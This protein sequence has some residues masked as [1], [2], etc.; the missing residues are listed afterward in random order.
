TLWDELRDV[1]LFWVGH[2]VKIFRVDNPHTKP[3]RFWDWV[4]AEVQDRHPDVIFLSEA[5][6]RPKVMRRLAKGGFSQSST[7]FTS[8]HPKSV[9]IAYFAELPRTELAEVMRPNLFANTPDILP[10][11]LQ[12]GGR[13]AFQV[14]LVLAATLGATYGIYGPPFELGVG[15]PVRPGSEEYRD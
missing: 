10:E 13:A 11:Y 7:Y 12:Y 6:T 9:L 8:R 2:G 15:V 14:R 5:F 1:F 3:F 4:I